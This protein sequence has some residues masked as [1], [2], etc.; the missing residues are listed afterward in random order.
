MTGEIL[1]SAIAEWVNAAVLHLGQE[2]LAAV[3]VALKEPDAD[4]HVEVRLREGS[5]LLVATSSEPV[6]QCVLFRQEV[7]PVRPD[8]GFGH[9]ETTAQH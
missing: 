5:V 4:L 2:Q 6:L 7:L 9:A 3:R 1:T 8:D